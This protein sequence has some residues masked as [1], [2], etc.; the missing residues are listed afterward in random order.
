MAKKQAKSAKTSAKKT[1]KK[2]PKTSPKRPAR[3]AASPKGAGQK[4]SAKSLKKPIKK[5]T[6]KVARKTGRSPAKPAARLSVA[7]KPKS[8]LTTR[9]ARTLPATKSDSVRPLNRGSTVPAAKKN[10]KKVSHPAPIAVEPAPVT[11]A[12]SIPPGTVP[13][14]PP[15]Q[16]KLPA[17]GER[18]P[19]FTLPSSTGAE[20]SLSDFAGKTVVL[21][22][23]PKA[24]TPGCTVQACSFRDSIADYGAAG[25][26]ILG[27]SPDPVDAV[28][29]FAEKYNVN[30]PLLADTDHKV[31]EAYGVW[32]EKSMYGK[33]YMGAARTTFIIKD[34][35]VSRVFE[36]VNPE[37]HEKEILQSLEG[38]H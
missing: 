4:G 24:D 25:L 21:Y 6:K 31:C 8:A 13:E 23:Y 22:F 1:A 30:F 19:E 37:G 11:P 5:S 3:K 33:T 10:S 17:V 2:T 34:G 15:P 18:A 20:V 14:A 32:V 12:V 16:A 27:I 29:A 36:K 38:P 26:N 9:S 7:D 28:K 35:V